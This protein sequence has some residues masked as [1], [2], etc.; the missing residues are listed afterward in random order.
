[1]PV[2][3]RPAVLGRHWPHTPLDDNGAA[4]DGRDALAVNASDDADDDDDSIGLEPAEAPRRTWRGGTAAG[5]DARSDDDDAE[6]VNDDGTVL[7]VGAPAPAR[8]PDTPLGDDTGPA[9]AGRASNAARAADGTATV[10]KTTRHRLPARLR[11]DCGPRGV[12][13]SQNSPPNPH[14]A[15][16]LVPGSCTTMP[17]TARSVRGG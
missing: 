4:V 10:E 11:H 2:R 8:S 17:S 1:M 6:K 7:A 16:E 5:V 14:P 12:A 15:L 13:S 9:L 3:D